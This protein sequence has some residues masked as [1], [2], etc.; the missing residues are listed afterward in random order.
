MSDQDPYQDGLEVVWRDPMGYDAKEHGPPYLPVTAAQRDE[1]RQFAKRCA[2]FYGTGQELVPQGSAYEIL[3]HLLAG[4][5]TLSM[6]HQT[7]HWQVRG[8]HFY[9]DHLLFARLYEESQA[10]IDGLAER[11]IGLT[12]D[13]GQVALCF[14]IG[15]MHQFVETLGGAH[16]VF[17]TSAILNKAAKKSDHSQA[18][19]APSPEGLVRRSLLGETVLIGSITHVKEALEA[20]GTLTEG[21]DDLLQSIASKHEEFVYLLKQRAAACRTARKTAHSYDRRE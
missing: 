4:L 18:L 7:A 9:G 2:A 21:L 17:A 14:Q 12:G 19:T 3:A 8:G 11:L 6:V 13:P 1:G 5:R 20:A 16:S 10:A 15:I